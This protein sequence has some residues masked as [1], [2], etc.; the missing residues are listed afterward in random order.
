[1]NTNTYKAPPSR[2]FAT[3]S[4]DTI[5]KHQKPQRYRTLGLFYFQIVSAMAAAVDTA[6]TVGLQRAACSHTP[7]AD[8]IFKRPVREILVKIGK[9]RLRDVGECLFR[10]KCLVR[11]NDDVRQRNKQR[12]RLVLERHIGAVFVEPFAFL[13]IDIESGRADCPF[14]QG[15]QKCLAVN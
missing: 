13:L 14:T 2:L 1:M 10:Q 9:R 5:I 6:R 15:G 11:R 4:S 7:I 3:R 12:K 8:F